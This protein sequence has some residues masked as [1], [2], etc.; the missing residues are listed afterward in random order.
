MAR[1]DDDGVDAAHGRGQTSIRIPPPRRPITIDIDHD[2]RRTRQGKDPVVVISLE[3]DDQA[4]MLQRVLPEPNA[5]EQAVTH[6][7][8]LLISP[9]NPDAGHVEIESLG[10]ARESIRSESHEPRFRKPHLA[11]E[12]EDD[13]CV[14][15]IRPSP[16]VSNITEPRRSF[17]AH[18][19][20]DE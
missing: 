18:H 11:R 13:T 16:N 17:D 2:S 19:P 4:R 20:G 8:S 10:S 7:D 5:G 15:R 6:L 12:F 14:V 3:V 1:V 9:T